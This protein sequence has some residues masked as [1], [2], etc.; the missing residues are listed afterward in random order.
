MNEQDPKDPKKPTE[1]ELIKLL[2]ELKK[3]QQKKPKMISVAFGF[4]L[5]KNYVIHLALS[6]IINLILGA[7]VIGISSGIEQPL[8]KVTLSGYFIG[9]ILF[10]LIE[11]FIKILMFKYFLRFMILSLGLSSLLISL[12]L[13]AIIDLYTPGFMYYGFEHLLAF[14]VLFILLRLMVSTYIRRMLYGEHITIIGGKK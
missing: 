4:L 9:M 6:L 3:R 13:F 8:M 1:E 10:T 14:T 7:V 11:N 12:A 5:H 2:E